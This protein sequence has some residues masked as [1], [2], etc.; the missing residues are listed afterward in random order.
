MR[1]L[2]RKV[3][4]VLGGVLISVNPR[5]LRLPPDYQREGLAGGASSRKGVTIDSST[6]ASPEIPM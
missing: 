4:V 3:D 2:D 1:R 6:F 5:S